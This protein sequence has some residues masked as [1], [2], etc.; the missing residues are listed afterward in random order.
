M[1]KLDQF[2]YP[3]QQKTQFCIDEIVPK[4]PDEMSDEKKHAWKFIP[5]AKTGITI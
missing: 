5:N 4:A 2:Q 3:N 1:F